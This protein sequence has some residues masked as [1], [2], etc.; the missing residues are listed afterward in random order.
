MLYL[1]DQEIDQLG[2][3]WGQTTD[4]I[5]QTVH[6]LRDN[7]YVQP[8]KPYLRYGDLRNR[9]IAMPAYAGGKVQRAGLKWVSSFPGN[10]E[11]GMQRAHSVTVLNE[12]NTGKP[13]AILNTA[14]VSGIRTAA[15]SG[16]VIRCYE[17]AGRLDDELKV[18]IVGFGPIGQLH[19]QMLSSLGGSVSS[20][21]LFTT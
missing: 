2:I 15:V 3:Q 16:A 6:I 4:M 18:G 13:L 19:L 14:R 1:N 17:D 20:R 8:V 10:L 12:P 7:D 11:Q 21:L 9:I 5:L